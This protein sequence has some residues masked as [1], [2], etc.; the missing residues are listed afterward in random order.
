MVERPRIKVS[1]GLAAEGGSSEGFARDL[2]LGGVFVETDAK[3]PA[4]GALIALAIEHS[5]TKVEVD[6][7]VLSIRAT[8]GGPTAPAG[9]A[10]RFIDLPNDAAAALHSILAATTP[11]KGTTLGLGEPEEGIAKYESEAKLPVSAPAPAPAAAPVSARVAAAAP[12]SGRMA[13]AKGER[14]S[15]REMLAAGPPPGPPPPPPAILSR[16]IEPLPTS[17]EPPSRMWLFVLV[18]VVV[19]LVGTGY[20]V[21][22]HM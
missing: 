11:R 6:G 4:E 21:L 12:A 9:F 18:A 8:S 7:R 20:A 5:T 19:V 3:A 16:P 14:S 2:S 1:Y 15:V 17:T 22:Q 10:V 13:A